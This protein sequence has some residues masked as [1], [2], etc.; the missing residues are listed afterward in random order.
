MNKTPIEHNALCIRNTVKRAG[1]PEDEHVKMI[2]DLA[3]TGI[4]MILKELAMC[5]V[6]LH[7]AIDRPKGVVP[8][9]AL[10]YYDPSFYES[11]R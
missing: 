1:K 10:R 7:D 4:D 9:S 6:A 8:D 3:C 5:K 11:N 2:A